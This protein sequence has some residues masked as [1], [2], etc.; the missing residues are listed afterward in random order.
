MLLCALA[1]ACGDAGDAPTNASEDDFCASYADLGTVTIPKLVAEIRQSQRSLPTGEELADILNDWIDE[2]A[3]VG[4]P[5]GISKEARR[6]FENW[7][8]SDIDPEDV[9][10]DEFA[11][12]DAAKEWDDLSSEDYHAARAYNTYLAD[13][14]SAYFR[15]RG[16]L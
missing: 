3:A 16:L 13:T 1:A 6:G 14:C 10:P 12:F 2:I 4:T 15:D 5:E 9:D 11:D 7:I 8:E